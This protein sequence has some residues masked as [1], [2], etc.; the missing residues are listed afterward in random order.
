MANSGDNPLGRY[1]KD[2]R[3]KLDPA[4][5]GFSPARRRTPG[6]RREEVAQRAN[7]SATWYTWL[8]Q[9]RG[10]TPSA[11]LLDRLARALELTAVEREHLFLIAQHRPPQVQY[12]APDRITAQLQRV[13]DSLTHSPAVVRTAVWD[14]VAWNA[15]AAAVLTDYAALAPGHRNIL[16]ILFC[17][18]RLRTALVDWERAAR[19]AVAAFRSET[20]RA[21]ATE[22]VGALVD[23]LMRSSPEF[24]AIWREHDVRAHG[25]GIKRLRHS[26]A[27]PITLEYSTFAVDGHPG[28]G[29]VIFTPATPVDAERIGSLVGGQR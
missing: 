2:R 23:E 28:L 8:E 18:A 26:S 16:R 10:G 11:D 24:E 14:V 9:G 5:F 17:D 19:A 4:V 22:R 1:L 27:G 12:E 20:A 7:V 13:L 29:L 3:A 15:A 21:G 6:L 25:E